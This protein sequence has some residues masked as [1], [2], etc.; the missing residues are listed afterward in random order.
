MGLCDALNLLWRSWCESRN[1][2]PDSIVITEVFL[3]FQYFL[4]KRED[5]TIYFF[6]VICSFLCVLKTPRDYCFP[7]EQRQRS[8]TKYETENMCKGVH[9]MIRSDSTNLLVQ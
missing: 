4:F 9:Y 3:L 8:D 6:L 5:Q 2:I 1:S 7:D